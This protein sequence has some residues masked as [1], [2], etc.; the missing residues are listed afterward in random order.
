VKVLCWVVPPDT[1][2][3][4][5]TEITNMKRYLMHPCAIL[6][7]VLSVTDPGGTVKSTYSYK[8]YLRVLSRIGHPWCVFLVSFMLSIVQC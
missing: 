3:M 2:G 4:E 8:I 1:L 5:L 6:F 7:V